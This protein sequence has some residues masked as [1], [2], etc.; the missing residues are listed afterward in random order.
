MASKKSVKPPLQ[1]LAKWGN[2][3]ALIVG[4]LTIVNGVLVILDM[5]GG[6]FSA[7]S[8]AILSG[9]II[10]ALGALVT[11]MELWKLPIKVQAIVTPNLLHG[12]V[13][14]VI[15]LLAGTFGGLAGWVLIVAGILY[16]VES[17]K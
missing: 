11:A 16:I 15:A 6:G 13:I 3:L 17:F 12:I 2:L 7:A 4:V 10:I 8:N 9:I 5:G 1:G 14:I